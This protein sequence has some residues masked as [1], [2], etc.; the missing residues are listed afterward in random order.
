M[1]QPE[2]K[3]EEKLSPE[4]RKELLEELREEVRE[5]VQEEVEAEERVREREGLLREVKPKPPT[6]GLA[7]A[8]LVLSIISAVL[9]VFGILTAILGIIFGATAVYQIGRGEKSGKGLAWAAVIVGIVVL[10]IQII[11]VLGS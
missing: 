9:P 6:S 7:I 8:G 1:A 3:P 5:E 2:E 10:V 11:L 4:E